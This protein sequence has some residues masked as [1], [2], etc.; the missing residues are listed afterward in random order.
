MLKFYFSR[1]TGGPIILHIFEGPN[2]SDVSQQLAQYLGNPIL[3]PVWALGYHVCRAPYL[4]AGQNGF[5]S[6]LTAMNDARI[7][8]D[9]DCIHQRLSRYAF[10]LDDHG[11][12]DDIDFDRDLGLLRT[13]GKKLMLHLPVQVD[14]KSN[15]YDRMDGLYLKFNESIE[16]EGYFARD[17]DPEADISEDYVDELVIPPTTFSLPDFEKAEVSTLW[18]SLLNEFIENNNMDDLMG[19]VVMMHSSPYAMIIGDCGT[20]REEFPYIPAGLGDNGLDGGTAC[21]NALQGEDDQDRHADKHNL[22]AM[23]AFKATATAATAGDFH[24]S[25]HSS[26]GVGSVGGVYS[27]DYLPTWSNMKR[28][29]AEVLELSL[30]GVPMVSMSTCGV[31]K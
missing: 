2:P 22:Y 8:Y 9:S 17:F 6:S 29:L 11:I 28:S 31:H 23:K 25:R 13:S 15:V 24:F 27:S 1:T 18:P 21:A 10:R 12:P 16:L 7:P 30:A 14:R 4:Y 3:P 19:G 5:G 26:P 20:T